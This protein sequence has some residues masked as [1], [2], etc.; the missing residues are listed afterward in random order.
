MSK[1]LTLLILVGNIGILFH[2]QYLYFVIH[3]R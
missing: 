1:K 3:S 2:L